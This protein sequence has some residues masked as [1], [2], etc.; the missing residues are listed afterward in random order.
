MTIDTKLL[1]E[2]IQ[3][4][5][6]SGLEYIM[7]EY[8]LKFG[9]DNLKDTD[10]LI[11]NGEVFYYKKS[12]NKDAKTVLFDAHIDHVSMRI[13]NITDNGFLICRSF[14]V[15]DAD[16]YGKEVKILTKKGLISGL[17]TIN[18]PH[19]DIKNKQLLV[20][21]FAKNKKEASKL[22]DIGD[23]I[24]YRPYCKIINNF[25]TG[26]SLD[27]HIGVFC[28]L[29][30]ALLVDKIENI[31][32][33]I[34]FHFSSRE[35]TGNLKYMSM[36]SEHTK[37]SKNINLIFVIDADL[38]ND[39]YNLIRDDLPESALGKGPIISRNIRDDFEVYEYIMS[40]IGKIPYQ[41]VMSDGDGGN[42]L[43][44]YGKLNVYGQS[45]GIPLRYM[46][47]SVETCYLDDL[48]WTIKLLFN[49]VSNLE[50]FKW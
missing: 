15:N 31:K 26:T 12:E 48:E 35:E 9:K 8:L 42:N 44:E 46:H 2:V 37:L 41:L 16:L 10:V 30:L 43:L 50:K 29:S 18:P 36:L 1:L 6:P 14:G 5:A 24:F 45:I 28:L 34:I 32:F 21:I 11:D 49:I 17:I 33:N 22:V 23:A 4:P 47:S 7:K 19:L 20:D 3:V 39:V 38:A 40:I 13:M 27:N 25:L